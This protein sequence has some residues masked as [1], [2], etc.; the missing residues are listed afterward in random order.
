MKSTLAK[1]NA[2]LALMILVVALASLAFNRHLIYQE[3][4]DHARQMLSGAVNRHIAQHL[5]ESGLRGEVPSAAKLTEIINE[6]LHMPEVSSFGAVLDAGKQIVGGV[7]LTQDV[8]KAV[9]ARP[10]DDGDYALTE[11]GDFVMLPVPVNEQSSI[12]AG[13]SKA[14]IAS[15]IWALTA[16]TALF[17]TAALTLYF[18]L[19][20]AALRRWIVG[21]LV[22]FLETRLRASIDG[23]VS[24]NP[25]PQLPEQRFDLLPAEISVNIERNMQALHTWA[26]HKANFDKFIA[27]S[28]AENNKQQL[29]GNLHNILALELPLKNLSILEINHSLNRL[30]VVY[31]AG[32]DDFQDDLLGDPQRCFVYRSGARLVQMPGETVCRHCRADTGDVLICKPLVAAGKEMGVCKVVLDNERMQHDL[33]SIGNGNPVAVAEAL[34]DTYIY[35]T[36]LS[37]SNLILLDSY[38]NQA[39]TDGLTGLYNRRYMT[40]YMASLLSISKRGCKSLALFMVD[41][42]NFKRLNDEYGHNVGD[43]VL[44][45]VAQTMRRA[46]RECDIIA[47]YGGEEFVVTLP[48]TDSSMASE[49]GERLREAVASIEWDGLGLGNIPQV[50]VSVGIAEF[51]LHGYSHYHLTNAADKALYVAKRTGKNRVVIHQPLPEDTSLAA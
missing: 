49:V 2:L 5:R 17:V 41:I 32:G 31:D 6:S 46:I 40:E 26:R 44:K 22:R 10:A 21:P 47:R 24:G 42:D 3:R 15:N 29:A 20:F 48:D 8:R 36:S 16:T 35:L 7:G 25:P 43:A 33:A 13:F 9:A 11:I 12:V 18:L 30:G 34:L 50:T 51:P 4:L 19:A 27:V 23:I 38:K 28:T 1:Y 37:L 45:A 14:S 39:I